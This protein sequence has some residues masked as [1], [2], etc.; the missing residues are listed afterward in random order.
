MNE[1]KKIETPKLFGG[2]K[3]KK[4]KGKGLSPGLMKT[5]LPKTGVKF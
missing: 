3:K 4:T 1:K 5:N 2:K